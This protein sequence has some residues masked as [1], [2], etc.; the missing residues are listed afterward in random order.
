MKTA[1]AFILAAVTGSV[2]VIVARFTQRRA[3]IG[4]LAVSSLVVQIKMA[5]VVR[6]GEWARAVIRTQAEKTDLNP[7]NERTNPRWTRSRSG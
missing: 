3:V 7:D 4:W 2:G 6:D 5:A 1:Y